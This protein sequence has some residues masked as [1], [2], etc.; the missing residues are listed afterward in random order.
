MKLLL[1]TL[2]LITQPVSVQD[3]FEKS[4]TTAD[5]AD[6]DVVFQNS[7]KQTCQLIWVDF[8]GLEVAYT[9][10]AAGAKAEASSQC[11]HLWRIRQNGKVIKNFRATA[12]ATQT[13][14]I[15]A[16]VGTGK[17]PA[18]KTNGAAPKLKSPTLVNSAP[19]LST[20][21]KKATPPGVPAKVSGKLPPPPGHIATRGGSKLPP[22]PGKALAPAPAHSPPPVN[23]PPVSKARIP[24]SGLRRSWRDVEQ[25]TFQM[26]PDGS[27]ILSANGEFERYFGKYQRF[28]EKSRSQHTIN[29]VSSNGNPL[30][31][32]DGTVV[33]TDPHTKQRISG[34]P[35]Q[36]THSSS[37]ALKMTFW[38]S[39]KDGTTVT[40]QPDGSWLYFKPGQ[41]P[42]AIEAAAKYDRSITFQDGTDGRVFMLCRG[43]ELTYDQTTGSFKPSS[44]GDWIQAVPKQ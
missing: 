6:C 25:S 32:Y 38:K 44:T 33:F 24:A 35:G 4:T 7:T 14:N 3:T 17:P 34:L 41:A 15:Q 8:K 13:L 39:A 18:L 9:D 43:I 22:P 36:W 5:A 30:E 21:M 1:T 28:T 10:I 31:L 11:G 40:K 20:S 12:A 37:V 29:L 27:W 42:H 26:Q 2:L 19:A 16:T 23:K